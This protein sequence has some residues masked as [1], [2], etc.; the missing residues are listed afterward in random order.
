MVDEQ[1]ELDRR[2]TEALT[3][4]RCARAVAERSPTGTTRWHEE[5][6]ERALNTLLDRRPRVQRTKS[7]DVL[8]A[9][10]SEG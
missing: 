4:L 9:T 1:T 6:A 7:A 5:M 10:R 8:V 3:A 2:I